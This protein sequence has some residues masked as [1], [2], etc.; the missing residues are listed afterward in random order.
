MLGA[1]LPLEFRKVLSYNKSLRYCVFS[2]SLS[3][4][5]GAVA[6]QEYEGVTPFAATLLGEYAAVQCALFALRQRLFLFG[7]S[8]RYAFCRLSESDR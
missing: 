8:A 6:A 5:A 1:E 4:E 3:A 7:Y 2:S